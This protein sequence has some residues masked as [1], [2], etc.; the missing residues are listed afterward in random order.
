MGKK[1][2][3]KLKVTENRDFINKMVS[4][5]KKACKKDGDFSAIFLTSADGAGASFVAGGA[6]DLHEMLVQTAKGDKHFATILRQASNEAGPGHTKD[7]IRD[8]ILGDTDSDNI[9]EVRLSDGTVGGFALDADSIES[10]TPQD[11]QDM[12]DRMIND[13]RSGRKS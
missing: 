11:I 3:R 6:E 5:V 13:Q 7:E 4:K 1:K 2:D 12:L 10:L 9:K 8:M